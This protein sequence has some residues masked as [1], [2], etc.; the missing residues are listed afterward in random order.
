V[1]RRDGHADDVHE[2]EAFDS[3]TPLFIIYPEPRAGFGGHRHN[4]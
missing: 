4:P 2:P 3:E 1:A